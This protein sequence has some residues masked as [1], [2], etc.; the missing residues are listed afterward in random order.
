VHYILESLVRSPLEGSRWTEL[1]MSMNNVG[2]R[3]GAKRRPRLGIVWK[4]AKLW[5]RDRTVVLNHATTDFCEVSYALEYRS[6]RHDYCR[7]RRHVDR[8]LERSGATIDGMTSWNVQQRYGFGSPLRGGSFGTKVCPVGFAGGP[9]T[10]R[11]LAVSRRWPNSSPVKEAV[12]TAA[13]FG[14]V[15]ICPI[16]PPRPCTDHFRT[17]GRHNIALTTV[18]MGAS[19]LPWKARRI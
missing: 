8:S 10:S 19:A 1:T 5:N 13:S 16:G 11:F 12:S 4:N 14:K 18:A 7:V 17:W 6:G 15:G 2:D 9:S 3:F